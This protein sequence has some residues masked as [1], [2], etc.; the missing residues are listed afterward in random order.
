MLGIVKGG[1]KVLMRRHRFRFGILVS[2]LSPCSLNEQVPNLCIRSTL[3]LQSVGKLIEEFKQI[4][5]SL[6]WRVAD[7]MMKC[8][9]Q[10][11]PCHQRSGAVTDLATGAQSSVELWPWSFWKSGRD[12]GINSY[13][14][15]KVPLI[16]YGCFE[17]V[18]FCEQVKDLWSINGFCTTVAW[19][20]I[21]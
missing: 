5:T 17:V 12:L 15:G 19:I 6:L 14:R 2:N 13:H 1:Q 9:W 7:I 18:T 11:V 16:L 10:A 8:T 21:W 3:S 4:L 20:T